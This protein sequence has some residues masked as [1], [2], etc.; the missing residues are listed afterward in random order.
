MDIW[1]SLVQVSDTQINFL[2]DKPNKYYNINT[3]LY[4]ESKKES[5]ICLIV[6]DNAARVRYVVSLNESI[7][8]DTI[9]SINKYYYLKLDYNSHSNSYRINNDIK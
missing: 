2:Q 3:G 7:F 1:C 4:F 9:M 8:R 6:I 5:D